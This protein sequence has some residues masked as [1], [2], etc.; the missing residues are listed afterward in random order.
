VAADDFIQFRVTSDVK[1][2]VRELADREGITESVLVRQLL[3]VMLRT[4]APLDLV[5]VS[6]PVRVN[7]ARRLYVRLAPDDWMLLNERATGRGMPSATYV[8]VLVRSHLR[9]VAPI[10]KAE[11]LA[12][13]QSISELGAVGRNLNQIARAVNQGGRPNLP[14]RNELLTM[15]K[16]AEALRDHFK[17]LLRAN[18]ASWFNGDPDGSPVRT[19]PLRS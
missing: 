19:G 16:I 18:A 3:D 1:S 10:P 4:R 2:R 9:G 15:L 6:H 8:S 17:G 14:G 7:R 13:R 11:Y 5:A 12:L